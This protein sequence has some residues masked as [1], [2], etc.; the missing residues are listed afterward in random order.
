MRRE[1]APGGLL[2]TALAIVASLCAAVAMAGEAPSFPE[3]LRQA[4]H[5]SPRLAE[6]AAEVLGSEGRARQAR[7]RPAPSLALEREDFSGR[8]LYRGS[9]QA[10]TTLSISE[11]IEIGGQRGA[12]IAAGEAGIAAA[13][14]RQAHGRAELGYE[15]AL[16]YADAEASAARI[17]LLTE[18]LVRAREDVRSARALV[19]AGKEGELRVVQA[20][21][22]AAAAQ[23]DLEAARA[24]AVAALNRLGALV[25][26]P[27]AYDS[28]QP[29]LLRATRSPSTG[30]V[31]LMR[32]PLVL[33]AEAERTS[34]ER[35][36]TVEEK[37]AIPIPAFTVGRRRLASADT[38]VWVAGFSVPLPITDRNR[39][40]IA[41]ARAELDAADA[42]LAAA[43]L[44]AESESRAAAAA[45][46]AA[47]SRLT[48]SEEGERFAR[49]AY[50][51]ARIGYESGRTPLFE[52]Q[53]TRRALVEAQ[54]RSLDARVARVAAEAALARLAGRVPFVE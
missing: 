19:D 38:N 49:E 10:Q 42:R 40:E 37:R 1:A 4:E 50:R 15:L 25:G 8:G 51:L 7:A 18:D 26:V 2:R 46:N 17:G 16:A 5:S 39:G 32:T 34:A 44:Q 23:A 12:R 35:L 11:P 36:V 21:A 22:G 30:D 52:L 54:L 47:E 33:A 53:S 31:D 6:L 27:N 48:A 29:S 14:A 9:A 24:E 3:L 43:H 45:A 13:R 41:A 20:D 28:V